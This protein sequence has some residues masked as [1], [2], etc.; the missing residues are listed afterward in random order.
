MK[1]SVQ[2]VRLGVVAGF[3]VL[4]AQNAKVS[5][6]LPPP[7]RILR[8]PLIRDRLRESDLPRLRHTTSG[9]SFGLVEFDILRKEKSRGGA[10]GEGWGYIRHSTMV[11]F[12]ASPPVCHPRL[13]HF[14]FS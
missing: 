12:P 1:Y 3:A 5:V 9:Y 11:C 14:T 7:S 6:P 8:L 13:I 10:G 4:S 2:G